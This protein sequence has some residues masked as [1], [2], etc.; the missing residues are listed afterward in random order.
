[1]N[2]M[3]VE[4]TTLAAVG[5]DEGQNVLEL[6]FRSGAIYQYFGVPSDVQEQLLE[7]A[8]LGSYFNGCI[9][10]RFPYRLLVNPGGGAGKAVLRS[11]G[12]RSWL[13]R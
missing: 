4:S 11:E 1:M 10:G 5:Y 9:R 2:R 8:S 12:V 3:A 13:G 7:S 6:E